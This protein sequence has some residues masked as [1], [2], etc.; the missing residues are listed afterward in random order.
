MSGPTPGQALRRVGMGGVPVSDCRGGTLLT[1]KEAASLFC[2]ARD[3]TLSELEGGAL[4]AHIRG[5][6]ACSIASRQL[7]T[8]FRQ[9]E[10]L[11]EDGVDG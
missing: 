4:E 2:D 10:H 5:C 8:I 1:C 3:R 6:K 9:L 7:Q 11:L